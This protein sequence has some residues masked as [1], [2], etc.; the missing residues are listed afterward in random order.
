MTLPACG[1]GVERSGVC[2]ECRRIAALQRGEERPFVA[3]VAVRRRESRWPEYLRR[4]TR[5]R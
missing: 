4:L 5:G 1:H 2:W 3:V